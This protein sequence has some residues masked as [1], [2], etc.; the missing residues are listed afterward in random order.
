MDE[1]FRNVTVFAK[2]WNRLPEGDVARELLC[3]VEKPT[4]S[5]GLTSGEH[6][7]VSGAPI[8]GRASVKSFQRLD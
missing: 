6:F 4:K 5:K 1:P 2:N 3:G 7:T 8:E